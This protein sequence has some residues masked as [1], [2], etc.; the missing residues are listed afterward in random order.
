MNTHIPLNSCSNGWILSAF[1]DEA[2][3]PLDEQIA[4]L[5]KAGLKFIDPRGVDGTN[6]SELPLDKAEAMRKKLDAAGIR[7]NMFGSPI[8]KIDIADD[9]NI[10]LNKLRHMAKLKPILGCNAVRI[11]SYY[12]KH[13]A[14][15]AQWQAESL[16][17]LTALRD[18]AAD[19][20][21]VLYHENEAKIFGDPATNNVIIADKLRGDGS[22]TFRMIFDFNNYNHGGEDCWANWQLLKDKTDA[23]H[24]KDSDANDQ[25]VPIGQGIGK[26]KEILSDALARGWKGP[27][28]LEPHL[29]HSAAVM[30]TGPGGKANQKLADMSTADVFHIAAQTATKLLGEI[31][32]PML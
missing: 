19:L 14:P 4:A 28:S 12:N 13:N 3:G 27:L 31:R 10:D 2:G 8:G 20:G 15:A 26:A 32:A 17:R 24:L 7:V 29:A 16:K 18:L 23:F 9:M 25:H 1:A 22:G 11:F 5:K 21:M 30:A 6:I